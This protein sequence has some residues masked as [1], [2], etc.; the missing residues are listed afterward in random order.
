MLPLAP[1]PLA[2]DYGDELRALPTQE[3]YNG[4]VQTHGIGVE[5]IS[6]LISF[7]KQPTRKRASR[8]ASSRASHRTIRRASRQASS[9]ARAEPTRK[10]ASEPLVKQPSSDTN[11]PQ[12]EP[13]RQLNKLVRSI[14]RNPLRLFTVNPFQWEVSKVCFRVRF[15]LLYDGLDSGND[16]KF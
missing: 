2:P 3:L 7:G 6:Y 14:E 16:R 5:R 13:L 15:Y 10:R 12:S 1:S 11:E 9:Q 8:R 4:N